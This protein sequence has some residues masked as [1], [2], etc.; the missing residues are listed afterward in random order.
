MSP[1]EGRGSRLTDASVGKGHKC[2]HRCFSRLTDASVGSQM[3]GEGGQARVTSTFGKKIEVQY[4]LMT[5][6][7]YR[8]KGY[9]MAKRKV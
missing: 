6:S 8:G 4:C 5:K 9:L 1:R 3:L 2:A 7:F